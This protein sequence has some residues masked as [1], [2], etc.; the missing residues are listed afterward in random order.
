M[1][2]VNNNSFFRKWHEKSLNQYYTLLRQ[3]NDLYYDYYLISFFFHLSENF[4]FFDN[5]ALTQ[6]DRSKSNQLLLWF[7]SEK[8]EKKHTMPIDRK[9]SLID[10]ICLWFVW[11]LFKK[12]GKI[13]EAKHRQKKKQMH[14]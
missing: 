9:E 12:Y 10:V 13:F 6:N 8:R 5:T 1:N 11:P 4:L 14:I 2:G 3:W 7:D